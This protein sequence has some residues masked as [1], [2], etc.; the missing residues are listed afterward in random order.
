MSIDVRY[1]LHLITAGRPHCAD[2]T[3]T[4]LC[5]LYPHIS[6]YTACY[7]KNTFTFIDDLFLQYLACVGSHLGLISFLL[8]CKLDLSL[9]SQTQSPRSELCYQHASERFSSVLCCERTWLL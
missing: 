7:N 8:K 5:I 1:F 6:K 4:Q 9:P 3:V 2:V